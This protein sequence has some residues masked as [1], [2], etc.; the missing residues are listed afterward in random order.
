MRIVDAATA[1]TDAIA[2]V[3]SNSPDNITAVLKIN[4]IK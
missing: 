1:E 2:K 4:I 3:R